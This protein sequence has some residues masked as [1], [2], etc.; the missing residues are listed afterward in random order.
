MLNTNIGFIGSG[1]MSRSLIGGLISSGVKPTSIYASDINTE[2]L[3]AL[4]SDFAIQPCEDNQQLLENCSIIVLSVKPQVMKDVVN[5]LDISN[6]TGVMFIT[7]AAG[8]R[9]ESIQAWLKQDVAIVRAMPNTPALVQTGATALYA[10][11]HT[12]DEQKQAAES[13]LRAVGLALWVKEESQMDA[14]TALS[15][16]GPAYFFLVMEAM[17]EAGIKLGLSQETSRLLAI[18]TAFGAAKLALEIEESPATLR[19]R[20]TS[21]KGTTEQALHVFNDSDLKAIFH[22]AMTAAR[23]RAIEL[24]NELGK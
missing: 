12:N 7:I 11:S 13:I 20:V 21:P 1:N 22:K 8:I 17:E 14:V 23:D 3:S 18:Q 15:G 5:S 2:A 10:N 4:T 16:S 9:I 19:E 6:K 24:A